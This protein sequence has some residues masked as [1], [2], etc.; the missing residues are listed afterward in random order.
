MTVVAVLVCLVVLTLVG[1]ALLKLGLIRRQINR[2]FETRLQAEWLLESGVHRALARSTEST[3]KGETWRLSRADLGL[4]EQGE[5]KKG[6][7]E[8]SA[9]AAIVTINVNQPATDAERRRIRVL[10]DYPLDGERRSLRSQELVIDLEPTK[11][12][13]KP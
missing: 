2:D 9:P 10:A 6:Q 11:A 13:A 1:A 4:P 5:H 12:G 8:A 7:S 3:Y